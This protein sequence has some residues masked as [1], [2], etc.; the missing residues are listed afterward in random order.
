MDCQLAMASGVTAA[1]LIATSLNITR[2]PSELFGVARLKG[3]SQ[4]H[5]NTPAIILVLGKGRQD[6]QEF[7]V[8]LS[9]QGA[10]SQPA[11][12]RLQGLKV[13]VCTLLQL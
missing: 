11:I 5:W 3:T 9:Q 12:L 7:K 1:Y 10:Q 13:T 8:I 6:Q 4:A 2:F